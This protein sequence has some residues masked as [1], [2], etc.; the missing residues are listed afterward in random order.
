MASAVLRLLSILVLGAVPVARAGEDVTLPPLERTTLS[1]GLRVVAAEY[2]ELP[3]VATALIIGSGAVQDPPGKEGLASLVAGMIRR[4][5]E[6]RSAQEFAEAVEFLGADVEASAGLDATV[7]SAEFLAK[8]VGAGLG[9]VAEMLLE[10]AFGRAEIRRERGE[11]LAAIRARNEEPSAIA[12]LCYPAFLYRGHAYGRP[13]EGNLETVNDIGRGD[14]R[15]F[16]EQHYTPN[17]TIAVIVGDLP[18]ARLVDEVRRAFGTWAPGAPPPAPPAPPAPVRSRRVLVV[19]NPGATQTQIRMGNVSIARRDPAYVTAQ[20]ANTVLGGGFSSRLIAELR[21]KR[22]LTYGAW[23][24]FVARRVPGDFQVAT[25][26]KVPTT[27]ET[28]RLALEEIGRFRAQPPTAEELAKARSYLRGQFP[29]KLQSPDAL[30][31]RLAEIEWY[32]L[33]LE[34]ITEFRSRVAAVTGAEVEA[35]VARAIPAPESMAVVVIGPAA[36]ITPA[37]EG[38]GPIETVSPEQCATLGPGPA[39]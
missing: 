35:F 3:L 14:V 32:G 37:L 30:A 23:S 16:H 34:E 15:A 39:E 6:T 22:S 36:A 2:H 38:L 27:G 29:Q 18:A 10:P 33:G 8:D 28:V 12:A 25:F 5:T 7:V 11:V 20:V 19:D 26:T 13:V 21:V 31:A 17:N 9:L 24:Y 1:N 4:G